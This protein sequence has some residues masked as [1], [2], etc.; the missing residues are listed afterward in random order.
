MFRT[1]SAE[2]LGGAR[3]MM[4]DFIGGEPA[5]QLRTQFADAEMLLIR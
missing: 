4:I 2:H 5:K 1:L 3:N